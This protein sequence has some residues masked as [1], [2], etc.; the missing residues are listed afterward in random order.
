MI[1]VYAIIVTV[2]LVFAAFTSV[3]FWR[4]IHDYKEE[5]LARNA[6]VV[7]LEGQK[8]AL[9]ISLDSLQ[10]VFFSLQQEKDQMSEELSASTNLLR[11][12]EVAIKKL[13]NQEASTLK[14]LKAQVAALEKSKTEYEALIASLKAEV[15]KLQQENQLLKDENVVLTTTTASLL[16]K[17]NDLGKK[18]DEQ[19]VKAQA[20]SFKATAF[21]V[22]VGAKGS[23]ITSRAAKVRDLSVSF[24]LSDVP[25]T[26]QGGQKLYLSITG[27]NGKPIAAKNPVNVTVTGANGDTPII[28]LQTKA[29]NLTASQRISFTHKIEDKLSAGNYLV[30]IYCD[31]GLL[32]SSSFKL[33][34]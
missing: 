1:R 21:R 12:K 11:S 5:I 32:G 6:Q 7:E 30:A 31:K 14:A 17:S 8:A 29:V 16:A 28:A 34:K 20:S 3:S 19:T 2:L 10:N 33:S 26:Y 23:K 25:E 18:L 13:R 24:D 15:E 4:N 22:E 9:Q 27:A